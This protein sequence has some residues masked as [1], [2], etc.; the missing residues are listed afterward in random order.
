MSTTRIDVARA[1]ELEI[2]PTEPRQP[3]GN[4]KCLMKSRVFLVRSQRSSGT[5]I[6]WIATNPSGT[7]HRSIVAK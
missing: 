5:Q 1:T 4:T 6:A 3:L 2:A 7:R